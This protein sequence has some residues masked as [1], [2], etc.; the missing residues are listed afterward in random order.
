MGDSN[1][2]EFLDFGFSADLKGT[3]LA[4]SENAVASPQISPQ[5]STPAPTQVIVRRSA[6]RK[7]TVSAFRE[8]SSIV[9]AIPARMSKRE[10]A[11]LVPEMV[12]KVERSERK[13]RPGDDELQTRAAKLSRELFDGK[14][15]PTS[16]RWS[17]QMLSRW[18]SCTLDDASI[19]ISTRIAGMPKYVLDYVLV[20]ELAHLLEAAHSER[21]YELER[22]YARTER[23]IGFLEGWQGGQSGISDLSDI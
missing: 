22:R 16:V 6:R 8:G 11:K 4:A 12:A 20:H 23:A 5:G 18:G 19:R 3:D 10:E 14:A 15:Q 1:F 7:R 13:L 9:V 17:S 2:S 21:F